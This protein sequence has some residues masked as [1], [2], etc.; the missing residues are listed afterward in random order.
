MNNGPLLLCLSKSEELLAIRQLVLATRYDVTAVRSVN[1]IEALSSDSAFDLLLICHT[2][3]DA[4]CGHAASIARRRWPHIKI[5]TMTTGFSS[6]SQEIS[7][8]RVGSLD[9]PM[10]L[11]RAITLLLSDCIPRPAGSVHL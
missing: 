2:L 7:D 11:F 5:I 1:E 6:C 8:L 4:E 9:G 3:S 10:P